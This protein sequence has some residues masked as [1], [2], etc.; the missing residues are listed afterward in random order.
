[1]KLKP[2]TSV[3]RLFITASMTR[4]AAVATAEDL[5]KVH[6]NQGYSQIA[7]HFVIERNGRVVEGRPRTVPGVLAGS[8]R[9]LDS[10]QVCLLGGVDDAMN[11]ADDFT[12][13]Q[14]KS[15]RRLRDELG[16]DPL[17]AHDFPGDPLNIR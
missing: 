9:N 1:M 10:L 13:A 4:P 8:K 3:S 16:L 15:L 5:A 11:P 6:R 12:P 14:R 7:V 17:Y 2:L